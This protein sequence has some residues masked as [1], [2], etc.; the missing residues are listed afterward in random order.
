MTPVVEYDSE[1]L[2]DEVNAALGG[3]DSVITKVL[4]VP[5]KNIV[6]AGEVPEFKTLVKV[7]IEQAPPKLK[8]DW[9]LSLPP[10]TRGRRL[11]VREKFRSHN[12]VRSGFEGFPRF[13]P[14]PTAGR[15]FFRA[16]VTK[17]VCSS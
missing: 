9:S 17:L 10:R 14:R 15:L 3:L 11:K 13:G 7:D 8:R 12:T 4:L 6:F 5:P 16:G 1:T 2:L